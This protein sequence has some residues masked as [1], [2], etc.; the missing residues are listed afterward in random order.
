MTGY[1]I[2]KR[3][4]LLLGYHDM[5][6]N[7]DNVKITAF[8]GMLKQIGEDLQIEGIKNM[9]DSITADKKQIEALIYGCAM[10]FSASLNDSGCAQMYSKIYNGKRSGALSKT[11]IRLDVLPNPTQG[12]I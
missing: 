10:L 12:G 11:D 5:A 9:T 2:F 8:S 6:E 7:A 1:D 3:V 4:C